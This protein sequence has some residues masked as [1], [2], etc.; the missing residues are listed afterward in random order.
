LPPVTDRL[1]PPPPL[2]DPLSQWELDAETARL[3]VQAEAEAAEF[4]RQKREREKAEEAERR[5]LQRMVEDEERQEAQRRQAEVDLETERLRKQYGV[6]PEADGPGE[7]ARPSRL[8]KDA[9]RRSHDFSDAHLIKPAAST[10][11]FMMSGANGNGASSS[12][13]H[14]PKPAKKKSFFGLRNIGSESP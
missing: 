3:Q 7:P 9:K 11:S 13:L 14:L 1:P 6:Q 8:R 12:A 10:S 4:R 2:A 5:R